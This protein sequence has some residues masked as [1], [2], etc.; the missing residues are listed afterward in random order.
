MEE[1]SISLG[2]PP[3]KTFY[4][5]VLPM[6]APAIA[7]A[8]ILTWTTSIAELSAS[9]LVYSAGQETLTI[10]V[11]RLIGSNLMAYASAYGLVLIAIILIPIVIA[12]KIFK[13]NIFA[14]K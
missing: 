10:Q 11:F 6:M 3:F 9:I 8:A 7:S 5:V 4:K 13:V 14:A 1:A 12:T 2:A